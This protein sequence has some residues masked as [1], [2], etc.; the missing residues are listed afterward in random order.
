VVWNTQGKEIAVFPALED[1]VPSVSE[2]FE[3][4]LSGLDARFEEM[5]A[6]NRLL[7]LM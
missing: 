6:M 4:E 1:V 5:N 3:E 7:I 2:A